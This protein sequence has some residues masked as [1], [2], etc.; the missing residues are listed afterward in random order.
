MQNSVL[1]R[2]KIALLLIVVILAGCNGEETAE[3]AP[4]SVAQDC[5]VDYDSNDAFYCTGLETMGAACSG[6]QN[7]GI[8]SNSLKVFESPFPAPASGWEDV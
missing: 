1:I 5:T 7:I 8:S 6:S 4:D 3:L 2:I